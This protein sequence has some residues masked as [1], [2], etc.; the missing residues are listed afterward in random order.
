MFLMGLFV[1]MFIGANVGL[2]IAG[3]LMRAKLEKRITR[4]QTIAATHHQMPKKPALPRA[5]K[6][7]C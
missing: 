2:V 3:M 4:C 6:P 7:F 1:G 5:S